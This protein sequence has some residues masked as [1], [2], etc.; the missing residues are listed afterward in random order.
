MQAQLFKA[1][2]V[3]KMM[4]A[5]EVRQASLVINLMEGQGYP[6]WYENFVDGMGAERAGAGGM[7]KCCYAS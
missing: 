4:Q 6:I 1:E 5:F 7:A 3:P 2:T